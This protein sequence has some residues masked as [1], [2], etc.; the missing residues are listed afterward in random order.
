[1]SAYAGDTGDKGLIPGSGRF[2]DLCTVFGL[3]HSFK[4]N[5][6]RPSLLMSFLAQI[7]VPYSYGK[8]KGSGPSSV[9]VS[10][11]SRGIDPACQVVNISGCLISQPQGQ[12]S[13]L[14]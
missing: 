1:M 7:L 4:C 9:T 12:D 13:W 8:R 2:I 10:W 11:L 5:T 14:F 3:S 6:L